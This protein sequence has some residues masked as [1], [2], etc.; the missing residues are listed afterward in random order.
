MCPARVA[1]G[2][3]PHVKPLPLKPSEYLRRNVWY[4]TSGMPWQTEV[5]FVRDMVGADRVMY[6]M[7]Y[8]YQYEPEEVA[9]QDALPI[10]DEE[11]YEFFEGIATKIFKL[12]LPAD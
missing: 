2:R 4:T 12:D 1:A 5:L 10:S 11:K 9:I 6:A 3:Y 7:D 8:P